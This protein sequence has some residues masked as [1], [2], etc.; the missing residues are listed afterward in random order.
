MSCLYSATKPALAF[1]L[2]A[3]LLTGCLANTEQFADPIVAPQANAPTADAT[4]PKSLPMAKDEK[5]LAERNRLNK[6]VNEKAPSQ[7]RYSLEVLN[8]GPDA[9]DYPAIEDLS[10]DEDPFRSVEERQ[11][12]KDELQSL[13]Q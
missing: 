2:A 3:I 4:G 8:Q 12:L 1:G 6:Y 7:L 5:L 9:G 11:K 10:S 13:S